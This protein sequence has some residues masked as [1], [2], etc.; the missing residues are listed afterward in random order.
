MFGEILL[1]TSIK[2]V[3]LVVDKKNVYTNCIIRAPQ[4][5]MTKKSFIITC[6]VMAKLK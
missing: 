3:E 6:I 5:F 1:K 4:L 2:H